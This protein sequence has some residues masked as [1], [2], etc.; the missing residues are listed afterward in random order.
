[1]I[2]HHPRIPDVTVDVEPAREKEWTQQ[3]WTKSKTK[4]VRETEAEQATDDN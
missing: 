2:P 3:G 1:M 4:R